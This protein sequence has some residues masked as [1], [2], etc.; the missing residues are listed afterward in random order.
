M[1]EERTFT[2]E[3]LQYIVDFS[4]NIDVKYNDIS[5]IMVYL[6]HLFSMQQVSSKYR[7]SGVKVFK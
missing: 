6:K 7:P 5:L 1:Y 3:I 4:I 2:S